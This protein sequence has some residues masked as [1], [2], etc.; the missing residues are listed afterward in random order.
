[1]KLI[2]CPECQDVLKLQMEKRECLCKKSGGCYTDKVHAEI[3][4]L[5][6]AIGFSNPSFTTAYS[7]RKSLD[8]TLQNFSAWIFGSTARNIKRI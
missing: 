2:F 1:M 5:A 3:W 4:G 7:H 8:P 6:E